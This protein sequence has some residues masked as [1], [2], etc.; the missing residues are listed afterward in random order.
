MGASRFLYRNRAICSVVAVTA[1]FSTPTA[2]A[3]VRIVAVGDSSIRGVG[4]SAN[5]TYPAQLEAALRARGYEVTVTNQGMNSDTAT[6]VLQRLDSA[7]PPGTNIV[8][9][10]IGE[11]ERK[12]NHASLD[13]VIAN[14]R[15]IR[16]RL[17]AKGVEVYTLVN[18]EQG[19]TS[20]GDLLVESYC[21]PLIACHL[22]EA[23][24]AIVVRRTPPAI[25]A[26]IRKV[27]KQGAWR[28]QCWHQPFPPR[29]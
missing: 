4:V 28:P 16:E 6:W 20:R 18:M 5:Q 22:N 23:G 9:L 14:K 7:V 8:I 1:L 21:S 13:T 11:H 15:T 27:E 29:H 26:L 25:E 2:L 3:E 24:L 19:M 17:S 10:K 12:V